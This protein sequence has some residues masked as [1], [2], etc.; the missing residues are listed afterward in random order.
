MNSNTAWTCADC[1]LISPL[2][3]ITNGLCKVYE[4]SFTVSSLGATPSNCNALTLSFNASNE[5]Y[6]I[7]PG[8]DCTAAATAPVSFNVWANWHWSAISKI[9][10]NASLVPEPLS[11]PI[12]TNFGQLHQL[13]S[14]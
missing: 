13:R 11:R 12:T 2:V 5:I 1:S 14:S 3:A 6:P 8:V 9:S 4:P 10:S 7:A